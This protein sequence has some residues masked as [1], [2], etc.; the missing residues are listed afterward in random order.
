MGVEGLL[1]ICQDCGSQFKK[2]GHN[3][4]HIYNGRC[5]KKN[6]KE[7]EKQEYQEAILSEHEE[8][9]EEVDDTGKHEEDRSIVIDGK[10]TIIE[11]EQ[12]LMIKLRIFR[13]PSIQTKFIKEEIGTQIC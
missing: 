13:S 4:H 11:E 12:K 10:M 1:F 9:S 2:R 5:L 6:V 8:E 7:R 3:R